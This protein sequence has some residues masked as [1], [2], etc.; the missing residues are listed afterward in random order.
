MVLTFCEAAEYGLL[1]DSLGFT[2]LIMRQ[3]PDPDIYTH[4]PDAWYIEAQYFEA[5]EQFVDT[6]NNRFTRRTPRP[7]AKGQPTIMCG[8]TFPDRDLPCL[9]QYPC[10][11]IEQH[12]AACA[13][14]TF[15]HERR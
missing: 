7:Q 9:Y 3:F 4:L 1:L 12:R 8:N 15:P 2:I 11:T 14:G 5:G 13:T 6:R 10:E